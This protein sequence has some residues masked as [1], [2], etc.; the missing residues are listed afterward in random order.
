M[1][2]AP[3]RLGA[4]AIKRQDAETPRR[5]EPPTRSR[6]G[7]AGCMTF[8]TRFTLSPNAKRS[9]A[10]PMAAECNRGGQPAL[11]DAFCSAWLSSCLRLATY[12]S[13]RFRTQTLQ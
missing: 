2:S 12:E 10:G 3:L 4:F 1:L 11:A 6:S 8:M 9:H 13:L 7:E 5:K